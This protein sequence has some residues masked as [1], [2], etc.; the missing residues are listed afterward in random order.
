M[1]LLDAP[2]RRAIVEE[3]TGASDGEG[4]EGLT[5]AEL[6]DRLD[7]H[8]TTIRFHLDRLEEAGLVGGHVV[9]TGGRGR[10]HHRFV[11]RGRVPEAPFEVLASVLTSIL[12]TARAQQVTP[13]QAGAQWALARAQERTLPPTPD[14]DERFSEVGRHVG[15]LLGEWGYTPQTDI[16]ADALTLTLTLRRCPFLELAQAHPDVVCGIH[17]G[18]LQGTLQAVGETGSRVTLEP[19][20]TPDTCV[21]RLRLAP[22]TGTDPE[23]R[24][25][26]STGGA[27]S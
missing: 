12:S 4:H 18:L 16:D 7:V 25:P 8:V 14:G 21:A 11:L 17:R 24:P 9:R 13:Q 15:D 22:R 5:A 27:P 23:T 20:V 1:S 6:A 2:L 19:L 3:L 26:H 10:P